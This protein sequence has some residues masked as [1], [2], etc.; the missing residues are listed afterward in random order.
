MPKI[1]RTAR[2]RRPKSPEEKQFFKD[3]GYRLGV[4]RRHLGHTPQSFAAAL[5]MTVRAYLAYERGERTSSGWWRVIRGVVPLTGISCDWW[6]TGT[7]DH[8]DKSSVRNDER[9]LYEGGRPIPPKLRLAG[10]AA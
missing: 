6:F 8:L 3:F 7:A 2:K 9:P 5:G 4:L 10:G 1:S